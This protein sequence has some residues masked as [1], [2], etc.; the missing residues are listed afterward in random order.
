M[1]Q[2]HFIGCC[3]WKNGS[4]YCLGNGKTR[5]LKEYVLAVK[6]IVN[7]ECEIGFGEIDYYPNQVMHLEA[8]I[9]NLVNDTGYIPKYTFEDGIRDLVL[10]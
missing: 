8:D 5:T 2:E 7:P 1:L 10:T 9:S 4:I 6:E 3:K